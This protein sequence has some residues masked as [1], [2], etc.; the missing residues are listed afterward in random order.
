MTSIKP[1]DHGI[2]VEGKESGLRYASL[3]ENFDPTTERKIR[4]LKPG[5][6]IF[7]YQPKRAPQ[8]SEED[9]EE[10]GA[11]A[12]TP[13]AAGEQAETQVAK[14]ADTSRTTTK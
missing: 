10:Q 7:S 1:S 6:S 5:E 12:P 11:P 13:G 3:D 4:D 8:S 2:V 9:A 14:A